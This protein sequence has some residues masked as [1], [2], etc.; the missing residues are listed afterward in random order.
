MVA[1][2]SPNIYLLIG[3]THYQ[4]NNYKEAIV[5]ISKAID[6]H[7]RNGKE[8]EENWLLLLRAI[9]YEM[10]NYEKMVAVLNELLRLYSKEEYLRTL[11]GV[12]SELE[13]PKKQLAIMEALYDRGYMKKSN[14]KLNLANMFL[15]HGVPFKAARLLQKLTD[16][17]DITINET[18]LRL[19]SQAWQQARDDKKAIPPLERAAA[20][21]SGGD[22]YVRL[23]QAYINLEK[24]QEAIGALNDALDKGNL[25]RPDAAHIMLGMAYF[26]Q[27][28]LELAKDAFI[29]A[30]KDKRSH[31]TANQWITYV[32]NEQERVKAIASLVN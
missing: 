13:Q 4:L 7:R 24:W 1:E 23:A 20:L 19:L 14:E 31:K 25:K 8:P 16:N 28:S 9:Y 17:K 30:S 11:A 22:L 5:P 26:N 12:Y 21:S 10:N 2:P 6:I 15:L 18:N 3:Q 29:K 32:E 27:K